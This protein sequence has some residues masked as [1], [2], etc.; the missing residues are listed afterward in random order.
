MVVTGAKSEEESRSAARMVAK[1]VRKLGFPVSFK[2]FRIQNLVGTGSVGFPVRLEGLADEQGRYSSVRAPPLFFSLCGPP[3]S[4]CTLVSPLPP[5]PL[6]VNAVFLSP[7]LP[8]IL[9]L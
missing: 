3:C 1:I 9:S 5:P 7:S 6:P 8:P 2:E 4:C